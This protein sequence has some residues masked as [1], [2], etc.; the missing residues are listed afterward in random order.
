MGRRP[1][2]TDRPQH[3]HAPDREARLDELNTQ[4][5][6]ALTNKRADDRKRLQ[7]ERKTYLRDLAAA[8]AREAR[9]LLK[10]RLDY[11]VFLYEAEQVGISATGETGTRNELYPNP[12]WDAAP[13]GPTALE[14]Y[15]QFRAQTA[16]APTV[17]TAAL[18]PAAA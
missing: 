10:Q 15:Q 17:A 2:R 9:A 16:A 13:D 8:I 1:E 3:P 11:P 5:A 4:L 6:D 18:A 7:A 12:T 14:L